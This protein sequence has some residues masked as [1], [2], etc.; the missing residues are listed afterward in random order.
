MP[1]DG[2]IAAKA[3]EAAATRYESQRKPDGGV[4]TNVMTSGIAVAELLRDGFPLASEDVES[5]NGSQVKGLGGSLVKKVLARHGETRK[6]TTEGGRTSRGTLPMARDLAKALGAALDPS[7]LDERGRNGVAD[8][9]Q[10]FFVE[11]VRKDFFDK[12]E[13]KVSIDCAKPVSALVGDILDAAQQR[14]DKPA[15][16]VAQHL[17]GAKLEL[18]FPEADVGR[19]KASSADMQTHRQGD[20][21][22]GN[23]AF[24]VTLAASLKLVDR[25]RENMRDGYRPAI[26]TTAER[27]SYYTTLFEDEDLGERVCVYG[28]EAF[29][30]TNVEEMGGFLASDIRQE[31]KNLVF[32]YN[33]RIVACEADQSLQI[34]VPAWMLDVEGTDY[35]PVEFG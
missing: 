9:L 5:K 10:A 25:V 28:I 24:H 35:G 19:D 8:A 14:E 18:R 33:E 21:E 26:V 13:I 11:R 17:V 16:I 15:G 20:F 22:L 32:K 30:G 31:L 3:V 34:E 29:V 6:F 27:L 23:T 1:S 12:Q 4:N 7:D 2:E